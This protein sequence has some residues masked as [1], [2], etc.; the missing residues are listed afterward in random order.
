MTI[1]FSGYSEATVAFLQ[2]FVKK[3]FQDKEAS[4]NSEG[5]TLDYTIGIDNDINNAAKC[6]PIDKANIPSRT[7][8]A[9][10]TI[11]SERG[12]DGNTKY[13][14][15]LYLNDAMFIRMVYQGIIPADFDK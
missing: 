13:N 5:N 10:Y 3:I 4:L 14:I 8:R 11:S 9:I 15:E 6:I 12:Y 7:A 2:N 1:T